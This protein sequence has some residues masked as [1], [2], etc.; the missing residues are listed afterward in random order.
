MF[1]VLYRLRLVDHVI[2]KTVLY[3]F[4]AT[5]KR[6]H[7]QKSQTMMRDEHAALPT[8]SKALARDLSLLSLSVSGITEKLMMN[9]FCRNAQYTNLL[10]TPK[11]RYRDNE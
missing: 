11:L 3:G 1:R 6:N 10:R 9:R 5:L 2:N 8:H 4:Q 7:F